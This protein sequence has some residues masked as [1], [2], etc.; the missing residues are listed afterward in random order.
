MIQAQH[1]P[2]DVAAGAAVAITEL[3]LL[4]VAAKSR[5]GA[6]LDQIS[7]WSFKYSAL[8]AALLFAI[9]FEI[10]STLFHVR[11]LLALLAAARIHLM[12]G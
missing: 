6:I 8:S 10:S 4:R 2:L 1:S 11:E 9:V 3:S 7:L 12:V 5:L